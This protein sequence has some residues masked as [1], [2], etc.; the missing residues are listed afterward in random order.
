MMS[1]FLCRCYVCTVL[2]FIHSIHS[3]VSLPVEQMAN[4]EWYYADVDNADVG[5]VSRVEFKK[6]FKAGRG[7]SPEPWS[8]DRLEEERERGRSHTHT[9]PSSFI[10]AV[11]FF[12][13]SPQ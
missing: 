3:W 7:E 9:P 8:Q 11:L 12:P 10:H 1:H 5:P 4:V 6:A 13:F 2:S